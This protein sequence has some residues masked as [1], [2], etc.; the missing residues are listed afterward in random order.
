MMMTPQLQSE[1]F[2][3]HVSPNITK[4]R[5]ATAILILVDRSHFVFSLFGFR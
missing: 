3:L 2:A 1:R 5:I 4:E